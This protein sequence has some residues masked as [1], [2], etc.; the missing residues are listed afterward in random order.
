MAPGVKSWH[1]PMVPPLA[2]RREGWTMRRRALFASILSA[3]LAAA[4]LVGVS[5]ASAGSRLA[6]ARTVAARPWLDA[7]LSPAQRAQLLPG[8]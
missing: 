6:R 8:R 5:G 2:L 3:V 1:R 4:M 7:A